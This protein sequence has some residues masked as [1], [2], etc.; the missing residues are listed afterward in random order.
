[1]IDSGGFNRNDNHLFNPNNNNNNNNNTNTYTTTEYK[2]KPS[3]ERL[4][5][6]EEAVPGRCH[7]LVA[8]DNEV[9]QKVL[10][11]LLKRLQ[12][13]VEVCANGRDALDK[14]LADPSKFD[15]VLMDVQMPIMDGYTAAMEIR[16]YPTLVHI[17]IIAM[18]ANA[19]P[20]D[21]ERCLNSGMDDYIAKPINMKVLTPIL[22]LWGKKTY[23][24]M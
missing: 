18:T 17:P 1:V 12:A 9:N 15:L 19:M 10:S 2:R 4:Y 11:L 8:E 20:G 22:Q 16:K 13:T 3:T 5:S 23:Q 14:L 24:L 21:R 6:H 7:V